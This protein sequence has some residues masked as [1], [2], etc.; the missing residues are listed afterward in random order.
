MA[1]E[2][3]FHVGQ[4][5]GLTGLSLLYWLLCVLG[6]NFTQVLMYKVIWTEYGWTNVNGLTENVEI[7][8]RHYQC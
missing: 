8:H 2:L 1:T 7:N 4:R 6:Q 5:L 3:D